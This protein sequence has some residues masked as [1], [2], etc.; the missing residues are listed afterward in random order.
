MDERP[1]SCK[2]QGIVFIRGSSPYLYKWEGFSWEARF[3]F[4]RARDHHYDRW[5]FVVMKGEGSNQWEHLKINEMGSYSKGVRFVFESE[6]SYSRMKF[7][8]HA[9]WGFKSVRAF[10]DQLDGIV[11]KR[12]EGFYLRDGSHLRDGGSYSC[13]RARIWEWGF[14]FE[15]EDL[16]SIMKFHIHARSRFIFMK[17]EGESVRG[18][19]LHS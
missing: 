1:E 7:H 17:G 15:S 12:G 3:I 4:G 16:Y 13:V 8:I 14:M 10:I 6:G 19:G 9:R 18:Q 5:G 2:R 11:P